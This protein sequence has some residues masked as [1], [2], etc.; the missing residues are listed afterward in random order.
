MED[1]DQENFFFFLNGYL[2]QM[3]ELRHVHPEVIQEYAFLW[4]HVVPFARKQIE[5]WVWF[6]VLRTCQEG[7]VSL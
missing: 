6:P 5:L 7:D 2:Y 3:P 4:A 1:H